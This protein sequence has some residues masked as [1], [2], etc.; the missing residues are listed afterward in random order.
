MDIVIGIVGI[1]KNGAEEEPATQK[2][3]CCPAMPAKAITEI[4]TFEA[5]VEDGPGTNKEPADDVVL[6]EVDVAAGADVA[7]VMMTSS[8]SMKGAADR[9]N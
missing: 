6:V 7:G 8:G 3:T 5:E 1:D 2:G 9:S 4:L